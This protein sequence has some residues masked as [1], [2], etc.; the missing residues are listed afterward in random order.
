MD[1]D[2]TPTPARLLAWWRGEGIRTFLTGDARPRPGLVGTFVYG[3]LFGGLLLDLITPQDLVVAI[4]YNIPITVSALAVSRYLTGSTIVTALVANLIAAYENAENIGSYDGIVLANRGL[5]ALSFLIVGAITLV[6]IRAVDQSRATPDVRDLAVREQ[7]PRVFRNAVAG[8][9]TTDELLHAAPEA[10]SVLL[11]A[12]GVAV[13]AA[14]DGQVSPEEST[15]R[16]ARRRSHADTNSPWATE[17]IPTSNRR[18]VTV[19]NDTGR[20]TVGWLRRPN[21][22]PRVVLVRS[23]TVD[24]PTQ[25]LADALD[26]LEALLRQHDDGGAGDPDESG[27]DLVHG[28]IQ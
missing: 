8:A 18:T 2:E 6:R 16:T 19:Q 23:P 4:L 25:L 15:P 13:D 17:S 11:D 14:H 10:L 22:D 9:V 26:I 7:R 27:P 20:T 1:H 24:D 12:S 21:G 3:L 28:G 5:A